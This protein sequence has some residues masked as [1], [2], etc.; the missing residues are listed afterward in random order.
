MKNENLKLAAKRKAFIDDLINNPIDN[1]KFTATFTKKSPNSGEVIFKD[2]N[3]DR[4]AKAL[5]GTLISNEM[6]MATLSNYD[7]APFLETE[8]DTYKSKIDEEIEI[9]NLLDRNK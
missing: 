6:I 7:A 4:I 2:K 3:V 9:Y 5:W 1:D 8:C